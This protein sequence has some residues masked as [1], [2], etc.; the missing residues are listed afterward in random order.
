MRTL[1]DITAKSRLPNRLAKPILGIRF[2]QVSGLKGV[3]SMLMVQ[4][5]EDIK[6]NLVLPHKACCAMV[7][8]YV[9]MSL[10]GVKRSLSKLSGKDVFHHKPSFIQ[11]G[12]HR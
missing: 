12:R 6:T 3:K 5:E 9:N 8:T 10:L 2:Q 4:G 11:L 7:A 1:N